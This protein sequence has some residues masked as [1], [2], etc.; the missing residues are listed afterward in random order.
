MTLAPSP[1]RVPTSADRGLSIALLAVGFLAT[2]GVVAVVINWTSV[3][4]NT[5]HWAKWML[6][7]VQIAIFA[8][9][10]GLCVVRLRAGKVGYVV[11][12]IGGV[13]ATLFFWITGF[14]LVGSLPCPSFC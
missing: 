4:G 3:M 12:F 2:I 6:L 13:V 8:A 14:L 9:S 11:P 5:L 1:R 10:L 7:A